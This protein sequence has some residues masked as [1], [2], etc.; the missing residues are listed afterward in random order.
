MFRCFQQGQSRAYVT[1]ETNQLTEI[2]EPNTSK[3]VEPLSTTL[4]ST[5]PKFFLFSKTVWGMI[6][7]AILVIAKWAGFNIDDTA[8]NAADVFEKIGAILVVLGL[9]T[10]TQ[11]LTFKTKFPVGTTNL[12][13]IGVMSMAA[14]L[15]VGLSSCASLKDFKIDSKASYRDPKTGAKAGMSYTDGQWKPWA[16]VPFLDKDGNVI[17]EFEVIT[18]DQ[19][20]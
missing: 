19:A 11:P 6:I 10:K 2:M 12:F 5:D 15:C 14:V 7:L 9:R 17:G 4:K 3:S 8:G 18:P 16:K 20:K 13:M 1:T